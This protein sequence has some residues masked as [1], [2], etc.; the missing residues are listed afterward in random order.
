MAAANPKHP[1][2]AKTAKLVEAPKLVFEVV[3]KLI[4]A[5]A[6]TTAPI[7]DKRVHLLELAKQKREPAVKMTGLVAPSPQI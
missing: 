5:K 3:V 7:I 6:T 1:T 2:S 4:N